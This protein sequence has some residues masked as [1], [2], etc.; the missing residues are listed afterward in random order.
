MT[1]F[2][3]IAY[4]IADLLADNGFGTLGTDIMVGQMDAEKNGVYI[5]STGGTANNYVPMKQ[6]VIDIYSKNT[7]AKDG[8]AKLRDILNFLDRLHSTNLQYNYIYSILTLSTIET[9]QRDNEYAKIMKVTL[10]VTHRDK[11]LIS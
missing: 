6:S 3:D 9:V 10:E 8:I 4:E 11:A 1:A 7:S 5:I 2:A